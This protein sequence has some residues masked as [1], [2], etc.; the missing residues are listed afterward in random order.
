MDTRTVRILSLFTGIGGLDVGVCDALR[1]LGFAPRVVCA[2][3]GEAYACAL[4]AA[5]AK[6]TAG[7]GGDHPIWSDVSTFD[8]GPWRGAVDL[9]IGGWPCANTSVCGDR[10]GL[11][12][13]K[14][15][16]F[17]QYARILRELGRPQFFMEN[18]AGMYVGN[19]LARVCGA[20]AS[21]GY[22]LEYASLRASEAVGCPHRRER[23]F[24]LGVADADDAPLGPRRPELRGA[25][26]DAD[27]ND[28]RVESWGRDG[29]CRPCQGELGDHGFDGLPPYPPGPEDLAGWRR[30]LAID[31]TLAP[32]VERSVCGVADGTSRT[33]A[34]RAP[35]NSCVPGQASA[36]YLSLMARYVG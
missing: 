27:S 32:A 14:S 12:G 34:L 26:P 31:P 1:R 20:L 35:G 28:V 22:H 4:L 36:A 3:E 13:S 6:D 11:E 23:W 2:V 5:K 21:L 10:A 25:V 9:V 33:D 24:C 16:L 8:P 29:S 19:T 7:L 18:V 17:F 15:S 30:V